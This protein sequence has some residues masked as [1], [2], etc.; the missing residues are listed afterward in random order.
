MFKVRDNTSYFPILRCTMQP[1]PQQRIIFA[2]WRNCTKTTNEKSL[3]RKFLSIPIA[4]HFSQSFYVYS[5]KLKRLKSITFHK[6]DLDSHS[7][8]F[9]AVTTQ[10]IFNYDIT[11]FSLRFFVICDTC[12]STSRLLVNFNILSPF[13]N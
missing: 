2:Q 11:S 7:G 13:S 6:N 12:R 9:F 4:A 8:G 1:T 5:I 3:K 10:K